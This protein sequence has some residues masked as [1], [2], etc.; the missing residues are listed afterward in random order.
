MYAYVR[1]HIWICLEC[2]SSVLSLAELKGLSPLRCGVM[3]RPTVTHYLNNRCVWVCVLLM[4]HEPPWGSVWLDWHSN[5]HHSDAISGALF[6]L[7]SLFSKG[8]LPALIRRWWISPLDPEAALV[9]MSAAVNSIRKIE[10]GEGEWEMRAGGDNTNQLYRWA[11]HFWKVSPSNVTFLCRKSHTEKKKCR[12]NVESW[13][14]SS[15]INSNYISPPAV[16]LWWA[17]ARLSCCSRTV[18]RSYMIWGYVLW[19]G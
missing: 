19:N 12:A 8:L 6:S 10:S 5:P 16:L 1:E 7:S 15:D 17:T 2:D 13:A 14:D 3:T 11:V 18:L 9:K 4:I